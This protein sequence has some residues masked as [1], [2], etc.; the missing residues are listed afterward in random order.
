MFKQRLLIA[1]ALAV[2]SSMAYAD[3]PQPPRAPAEFAQLDFFVGTWHCSGKAFA[4]PM[5]PEHATTASVNTA[6][7]VDGHWLHVTY[8]EHKTAANPVPY[9]VGVYMGYDAGK[10]E[11]V[12]GCV[13][14]MGGYC[15]ENS[16]GW[17]GDTIS[18][19]G[20]GHGDGKT[21]G[22]R[23]NFTRKDANEFIHSGEM[24]GEDKKWMKL[25]EETCHRAK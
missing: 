21:F 6:K 20:T 2:A 16:Q 22:V 24:Q 5:G 3:A 19:E 18:F 15:T 9:H 8:D 23:D 11:F 13:D 12:Q 4:S 25:D 10:K 17:S 14:N 7:A 1:A